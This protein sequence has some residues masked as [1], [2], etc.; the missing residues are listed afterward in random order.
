MKRVCVFTA[1]RAEYG[2]LYWTLRELESAADFELRL[3][4]TGMHLSPEFGETAAQIERDGFQIDERIESLLSSDTAVGVAKSMGLCTLGCADALA[5]LKP[6]ALLLLGD[7][8]EVLA[9]AQAALVAGIPIVHIHGGE[10]T[11]GAYDDAVRHA[12]TKM[13]ALHFT[14]AEPFRRRVIQLGENPAAVVVSGAPGLDHL[15]RTALLDRPALE[16][17]LGF[18]LGENSCL[19]TYHP[20]T[21]ALGRNAERFGELLSALD[22]FPHLRCVITYP[23]ADNE[24]RRLIQMLEAFAAARPERVLARKSLGQ[25]RYLSLLKHARLVIG[26]SS[27]GLIEAPSF[28]LP[29][30]NI[31]ERQRGRPLADS[32]I[33]CP[34]S[35]DAIALAM[36]RGQEPAFRERARTCKN[37][38]GQGQAAQIIVETLRRVDLPSLQRKGFYDLPDASL[39]DGPG[40]RVRHRRSGS[41]PQR[42]ARH[43]G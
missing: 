40:S 19:V 27:S 15:S 39:S 3:L 29:T 28:G 5:R 36:E 18:E 31:G 43:G 23:N 30:I 21:R 12:V 10:V 42:F 11:E 6:D 38:Y 1:T 32:V 41:E 14:S 22:R 4:V 2:L 35:A 37:P 9:A 17:E 24:G 16:R 8:F 34:P 13:A 20:E 26:N 25:L 7:R 33:C